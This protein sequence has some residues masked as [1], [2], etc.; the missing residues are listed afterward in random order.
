MGCCAVLPAVRKAHEAR[1]ILFLMAEVAK[2]NFD[3]P[4]DRYIALTSAFVALAGAMELSVTD[5]RAIRRE[6]AQ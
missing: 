2:K 5:T 1:K 3:H 6:L 4:G